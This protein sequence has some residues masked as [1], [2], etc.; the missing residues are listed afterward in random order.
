MFW[1]TIT[2]I[3]PSVTPSVT[4]S[5]LGGGG[6]GK[7]STVFGLT[8]FLDTSPVSASGCNCGQSDAEAPATAMNG[9]SPERTYLQIYLQQHVTSCAKI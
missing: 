6:H 7:H 5:H 1:P 4:V 9:A 2:P 3:P 8:P